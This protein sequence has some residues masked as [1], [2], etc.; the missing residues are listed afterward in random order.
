MKD[1]EQLEAEAKKYGETFKNQNGVYSY[2]QVLIHLVDFALSQQSKEET[3][4]EVLSRFKENGF[5]MYKTADL[6]PKLDELERLREVANLI[7]KLLETLKGC[8][9]A[10]NNSA[11]NLQKICQEI[12]ELTLPKGDKTGS[13]DIMLGDFDTRKD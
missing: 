8:K 11:N 4:Q 1:R 3:E 12:K 6:K 7:P 5:E 10:S 9:I 2:N 13:D